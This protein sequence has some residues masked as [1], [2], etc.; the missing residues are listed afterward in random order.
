MQKMLFLF[1]AWLYGI[2]GMGGGVLIF[3]G[4]GVVAD[5]SLKCLSVFPMKYHFYL[6][7]STFGVVFTVRI[8]I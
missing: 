2:D 6:L 3:R 1:I 4:Y 5:E 7:Q 8:Y